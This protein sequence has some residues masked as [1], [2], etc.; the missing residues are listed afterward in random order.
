MLSSGPLSSQKKKTEREHLRGVDGHFLCE[1]DQHRTPYRA[2]TAEFH[3]KREKLAAPGKGDL[4]IICHKQTG[5]DGMLDAALPIYAGRLHAPLPCVCLL[6]SLDN[7]QPQQAQQCH[8]A[9]PR[10]TVAAGA[11]AVG[12]RFVVGSLPA[13]ETTLTVTV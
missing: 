11:A 13:P 7:R 3:A 10:V 2:I 8:R 1:G 6:P 9:K 5:D 4:H 12:R